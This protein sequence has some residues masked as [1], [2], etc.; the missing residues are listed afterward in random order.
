LD[1]F[2]TWSNYAIKT[3]QQQPVSSQ[4]NGDWKTHHLYFCKTSQ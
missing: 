4:K 1:Y 2:L 3:P